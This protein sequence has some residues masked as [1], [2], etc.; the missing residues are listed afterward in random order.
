MNTMALSSTGQHWTASPG[1]A[2]A[3]CSVQHIR[4]HTQSTSPASLANKLVDLYATSAQHQ[5]YPPLPV[6]VPSFTMDRFTP[7]HASYGYVEANLS[8]FVPHL[9]A[10]TLSQDSSFRPLHRLPRFLYDNHPPLAHPYLHA[11]SAF[12]A[13]LQLYLGSAQLADKGRVHIIPAMRITSFAPS[14]QSVQEIDYRT[15]WSRIVF[16]SPVARPAKNWQLDRTENGC[17]RTAV[18]VLRVLTLARSGYNTFKD[19]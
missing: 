8:S 4:T 3:H 14:F 6:P 1:F 2:D 7:F 19:N 9:L 12:S 16:K 15:A 13:T 11:S 10:F 17:N 18:A 5:P